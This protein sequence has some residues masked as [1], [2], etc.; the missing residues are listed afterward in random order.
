MFRGRLGTAGSG[1]VKVW[2]DLKRDVLLFCDAEKEKKKK[3]KSTQSKAE[4][5]KYAHLWLDC[6]ENRS[7]HERNLTLKGIKDNRCQGKI[8]S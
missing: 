7:I 4:T 5:N 1:M 8:Q 3:K 2:T 6:F